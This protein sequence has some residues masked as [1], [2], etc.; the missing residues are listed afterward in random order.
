MALG[1]DDKDNS[2]DLDFDEF[3]AA[4]RKGGQM[5]HGVISDEELRTLFAAV[6][7]DN[8]GDVSIE[9]L[10]EF[11]W[12]PQQ[13]SPTPEPEP[14]RA[15]PVAVRAQGPPARPEA[16]AEAAAAA[17]QQADGLYALRVSGHP[18]C[19]GIF[20]PTAAHGGWPRF[21]SESGTHLYHHAPTRQWVLADSFEPRWL[22]VVSESGDAPA[23]ILSEEGPVP[24][25]PQAW[26]CGSIT[27]TVLQTAD[28]ALAA[29]AEDHRQA[30][31]LQQQVSK[32]T[33]GLGC[34]WC[35]L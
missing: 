34:E 22:Q 12:G 16:T 18:A 30:T 20:T 35:R 24:T 3:V 31:E 21:R 7:G 26:S 33:V 14:P 19:S 17:R 10:T 15:R 11:V 9:E 1:T 32:A 6:D 27:I 13:R 2:G 29:S 4:I 8:S 5:T 28:D 25:G 23:T